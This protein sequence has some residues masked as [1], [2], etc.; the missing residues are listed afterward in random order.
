[1][2]QKCV[3]EESGYKFWT[4]CTDLLRDGWKVIPGTVAVSV[5]SNRDGYDAKETHVAFFTDGKDGE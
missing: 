5:S 3:H 4:V 1:M 2:A